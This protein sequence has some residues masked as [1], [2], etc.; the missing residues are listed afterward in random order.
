MLASPNDS[1]G[2]R[3]FE[4]SSGLA[5]ADEVGDFADSVLRPGAAAGL[6]GHVGGIVRSASACEGVCGQRP[7]DLGPREASP[8]DWESEIKECECGQVASVGPWWRNES[9][10]PPVEAGN[11]M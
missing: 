9:L 7:E 8:T 6:L 1:R 11:R 10:E 3:E 2:R 5:V 4:V